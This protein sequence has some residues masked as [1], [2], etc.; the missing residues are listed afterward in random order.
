[1]ATIGFV[2][3]GASNP[4]SALP[5]FARQ[6]GQPCGACHVDFPGLTPFGRQFKLGGYTLGGGDYQTTPFEGGGDAAAKALNTYAKKIKDKDK[7][8]AD[9]APSGDQGYHG[10]VPPIAMMSIFQFTHQ[11]ADRDPADVTPFKTNDNVTSTRPAF[12]MVGP[13]PSTWALSFNGPMN[14]TSAVS[15]TP[16]LMPARNG[17]GTTSIFAPRTLARSATW[18]SLTALQ[19]P[20]IRAWPTLGTPRRSGASRTLTQVTLRLVRRR[21]RCSTARGVSWW[22]E[23]AATAGST[24]FSMSNSPISESRSRHIGRPRGH[25]IR[26]SWQ[27]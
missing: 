7:K 4:A 19:P 3:V 24:I 15:I 26:R 11:N 13:S 18:T 9:G 12:S 10:W 14:Q 20:I 6:T 16:T 21:R 5:S 23:S 22:V 27:D 17:I 8:T 1:M 25:S 2:A